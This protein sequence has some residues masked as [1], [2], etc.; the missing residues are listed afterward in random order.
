[1]SDN[2]RSRYNWVFESIGIGFDKEALIHDYIEET[3]IRTQEM[4]KYD[5][6][7]ETIPQKDLEI[8]LQVQ[9]SCTVAKVNDKLYAFRSGLG[10]KPNVYYLPTLSIVANPALNLSESYVIDENCVVILNDNMYHGIMPIITRNANLLAECD[11][12]F[13]FAAIN[14]RIP[15]L[16]GAPDDDTKESAEEFFKQIEEGKKLGVIAD[17]SF[18]GR[19]GSYSYN[20]SHDVITDL[21]EL[22]QYIWGTFYQQ[23]G[24]QANFNMKREAINES[25]ASLSLDLLIPLCDQMLEQ[26]KI[27]IEKIN[28][29]FGTSITVEFSSV[30]KSLREKQRLGIKSIE[31]EIDAEKNDGDKKDKEVQNDETD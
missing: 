20:N 29:M 18:I 10:G 7:P 8:I 23:L 11:I 6:L 9:G 27:G 15:A 4:F 19:L 31:A 17:D 28:R 30:W 5:N 16:V 1:M 21:I 12:S 3:L 14:S 2:V 13:K 24:I 22:K 25:E 26:R